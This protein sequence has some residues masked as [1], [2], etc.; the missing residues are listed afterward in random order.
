MPEKHGMSIL[1]GQ[2]ESI[3]RSNTAQLRKS[4]LWNLQENNLQVP[5]RGYEEQFPV[6]KISYHWHI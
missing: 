3:G 5:Y 2:F 4:L 6:G 1:L